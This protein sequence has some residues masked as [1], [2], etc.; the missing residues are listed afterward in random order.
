MP[1][2]PR[3]WFLACLIAVVTISPAAAA[4]VPGDAKLVKPRAIGAAAP[5]FVV[6]REDGLAYAFEPAKLAKPTVLIFYRGGWCPYCNSNL[7]EL[8]KAESELE[9]TG[10]DMLFLSGDNPEVLR[11]SLKD[12]KVTYTLLSDSRMAAARAF[13]VAFQLDDATYEQYKEYGIDLEEASGETHHQLPVPAVFIVD[14]SGTIR[15]VYANPDYKE[16]LKSADLL[17]AARKLN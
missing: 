10:F 13:G 6:R 2:T 8:R 17:A 14:K 11:S 4:G 5:S 3:A 16:R 15:F 7:A 12:P 9:R 1:M